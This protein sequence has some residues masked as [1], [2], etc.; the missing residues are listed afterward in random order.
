MKRWLSMILLICLLA[1]CADYAPRETD[2]PQNTIPPSTSPVLA[3]SPAE[4]D[5]TIPETTEVPET[6][7]PFEDCLYHA[8]LMDAHFVHESS[9][10]TNCT[11]DRCYLEFRYEGTEP[12]VYNPIFHMTLTLPEEWLDQVEIVT[13]PTAMYVIS[14][15]LR[16]AHRDRIK[17][18]DPGLSDEDVYKDTYWTTTLAQYLICIERVHREEYDN[19][20]EFPRCDGYDPYENPVNGVFLYEDA[21]YFY[22][23]IIGGDE[24]HQNNRWFMD[25]LLIEY[26]GE[27][28]FNALLDG[29]E[30]DY[31]MVRNM[32]QFDESA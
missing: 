2:P 24:L 28:A 22:Y 5:V 16:D 11:A 10:P 6:T 23:G 29:W 19:P 26:L 25:T 15:E 3:T 7:I 18:N 21:D 14:K 9:N 20:D 27:D 13:T 8:E 4:T 17:A 12:A 30:L 31:D 32:V 1:G